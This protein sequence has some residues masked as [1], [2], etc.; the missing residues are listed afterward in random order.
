MMK[1]AFRGN[2]TAF[3]LFD[4]LPLRDAVAQRLKWLICFEH[5]E[6]FDESPL[7][8]VLFPLTE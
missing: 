6:S 5:E 3:E 8:L 2:V 4:V 1:R 7:V